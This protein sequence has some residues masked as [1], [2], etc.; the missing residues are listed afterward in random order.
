MRLLSAVMGTTSME[1]RR[2]ETKQLFDWGFRTFNTVH[3][4][5]HKTVPASLP[6]YQGTAEKVAIAPASETYVTCLRGK[7]NQVTASYIGN[8]K[9]LVAPVAK[10]AVAG[11]M[12]VMQEGKQIASIPVVAQSAVPAAGFFKRM[13]DKLRMKL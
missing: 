9:Y 5:W 12:A 8:T 3:P 6:V 7:E 10:G 4:D 13:K 11:S 1:K 2:V